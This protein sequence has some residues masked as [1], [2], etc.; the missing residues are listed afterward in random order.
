MRPELWTLP[1]SGER[2]QA[3][4]A[5]FAGRPDVLSVEDVAEVL[6]VTRTN[7][8][9]WLRDGVIPGYK[10]GTTWR[11]LRDE[12]KATMA[13]LGPYVSILGNIIGTGP[14]FDAYVVNLLAIPTGEFLPGSLED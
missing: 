14:W 4:D 8:Y 13:A 7:V 9:A 2:E 6:N 1:V 10:L 11:V 5:L 12:L 3:L